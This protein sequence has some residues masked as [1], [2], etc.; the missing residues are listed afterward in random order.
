MFRL[1]FYAPT[2]CDDYDLI[3]G[4]KTMKTNK[5]SKKSNQITSGHFW[6]TLPLKST[7]QA[8]KKAAYRLECEE[9]PVS[10]VE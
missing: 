3:F 2:H 4:I 1:Y 10:V 8:E 5:S 6:N 9:N 7:Q